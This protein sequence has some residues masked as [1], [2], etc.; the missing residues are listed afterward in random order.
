MEADITVNRIEKKNKYVDKFYEKM[1]K[2][3]TYFYFSLAT[4]K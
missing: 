2:G 3:K 1:K 4:K